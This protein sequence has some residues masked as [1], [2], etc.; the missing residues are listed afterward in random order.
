MSWLGQQGI[1]FGP[2]LDGTRLSS[3]GSFGDEV[4]R[5]D[6][7]EAISEFL[8]FALGCRARHGDVEGARGVDGSLEADA[9]ARYA[10]AGGGLGFEAADE[11]VGGQIGI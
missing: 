9:M 3:P 1:W 5:D 10:V 11:V 7:E 2:S 6:L 4:K 8:G